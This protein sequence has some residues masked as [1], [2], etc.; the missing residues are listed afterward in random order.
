MWST[1][2]L[3][4]VLKLD[5]L[6][7]LQQSPY[8]SPYSKSRDWER[9]I[10]SSRTPTRAFRVGRP[11]LS[12][13]ALSPMGVREGPYSTV[14]FVPPRALRSL[15]EMFAAFILFPLLKRRCPYLTTIEKLQDWFGKRQR[16]EAWDRGWFAY[17]EKRFSLIWILIWARLSSKNLASQW[18]LVVVWFI[19]F[20]CPANRNLVGTV[21]RAGENW[22]E[23][24]HRQK[25]GHAPCQ[26]MLRCQ[27]LG[28]CTKYEFFEL[29]IFHSWYLSNLR[30]DFTYML[31]VIKSIKQDL[32]W[33]YFLIWKK[34]MTYGPHISY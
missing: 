28:G 31:L 18:N 34:I 32:T 12:I 14:A 21:D 3:G 6:E 4:T 26:C 27:P 20:H 7:H 17:T 10:Y 24:N 19:A 9:K 5:T 13:S 25:Y 15:R 11:L 22:R 1:L 33:L 30:F 29:T 16:Q 8:S 2:T 23:Q